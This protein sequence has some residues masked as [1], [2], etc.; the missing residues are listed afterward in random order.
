MNFFNLLTDRCALKKPLIRH[1][2]CRFDVE[3][4]VLLCRIGE[5]MLVQCKTAIKAHS[6]VI[7]FGT[8]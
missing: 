4:Y 1:Y 6:L 5:D 2:I 7:A 3:S 8:W